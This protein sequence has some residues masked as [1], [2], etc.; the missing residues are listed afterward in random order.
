MEF[1]EI[2]SQEMDCFCDICDEFYC[3][4]CDTSL[5]DHEGDNGDDRLDYS[6]PER[7]ATKC[8]K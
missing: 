7:E 3:S 8:A 6:K 5:H 4:C 1:C 2:C